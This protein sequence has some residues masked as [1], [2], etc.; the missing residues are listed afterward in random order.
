MLGN[1]PFPLAGPPWQQLGQAPPTPHSPPPPSGGGGP[2]FLGPMPIGVAPAVAMPSLPTFQGPLGPLEI[3]GLV[4]RV[5]LDA[6]LE[7]TIEAVGSSQLVV[8]TAGLRFCGYT[9][10]ETGGGVATAVVR[11]GV[12]AAAPVLAF[13]NL[14][15]GQGGN[16]VF[17]VGL[18]ASEGLYFQLAS[19]AMSFVAYYKIVPERV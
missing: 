11:R 10:R 18:R 12:G 16:T 5:E 9:A 15:A 1:L 19:G 14:S 13:I 6:P 2:A 3:A 7:I 17:P 4:Q 8:A